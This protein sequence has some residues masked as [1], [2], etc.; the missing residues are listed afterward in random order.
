[1]KSSDT[2]SSITASRSRTSRTPVTY[3]CEWATGGTYESSGVKPGMQQVGTFAHGNCT[4]PYEGGRWTA[5]TTALL[6]SL[7]LSS[8]P[9]LSLLLTPLPLP[10][11]CLLLLSLRDP[12][13]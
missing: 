10:L 13:P 8:L 12:P 7:L 11:L 2:S 1:M 3:T 5:G 4:R 9:L 6:S